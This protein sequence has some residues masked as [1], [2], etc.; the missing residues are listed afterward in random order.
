[1]IIVYTQSCQIH[2]LVNENQGQKNANDITFRLSSNMLG[3]NN[4][5]LLCHY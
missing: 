1:M 4:T 2:K 3:S 5:D